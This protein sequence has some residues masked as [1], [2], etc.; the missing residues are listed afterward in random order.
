MADL[1]AITLLALAVAAGGLLAHRVRMPPALGYLGVGILFGSWQ[2]HLV[3]HAMVSLAEGGILILLFLIGLEL[4]LPR[5]RRAL[6]STAWAMPF[7][8]MVPA[9]LVAG[10]ARFMGWPFMQAVALG[11][12]M[13]VSSTLFGERVAAQP[14]TEPGA[15]QRVLGVL[16]SEDVAAGALIAILVVLASGATDLGTPA[17]A[18]GQTIF[19]LLL[20]TGAGLMLV[21]RLLD[22]VARRHVPELLVLWTL[23]LVA[24]FGYIGH[25]AGSAELGALVAGV[26]AAEAGSRFVARN[27]LTGL[28]HVAAALFFFAAGWAVDPISA[29]KFAPL[30]LLVAAAFVVAKHLVH[31]PSA[32]AAGL[33]LKASLQ[34]GAALAAIGEF[35]LILVAV[36]EREGLAHPAMRDV[37]VGAMITLLPISAL[38]GMT[39]S[40][41]SRWF[42]RWPAPVRAPLEVLVQAMRRRPKTVASQNRWQQPLRGLAVNSLLVAALM[43]L[44]VVLEPLVP[45]LPGPAY[46][47][48]A[49]WLG[50]TVALALPLLRGWYRNY[51][52]LV[53]AL[54]G[55]QPG[56]RVGAGKVRALFV[57]AWVAATVVLVLGFIS[58]WVPRTLPVVA[59]AAV[60]A[61]IIATIA[62]R[63]LTRF[64]QA[65]EA[66][67]GRVLGDDQ[68]SARFLDEIMDEYPWGVRFAAVSV[69]PRSPVAGSTL[70]ESRIGAL[71]GATVAVV[72]RGKQETVNP[73]SDTRL[74]AGDTLV[75]LGDT[76]QLSRAEA[77]VVAHGEVVRLSAQSLA[78]EVE[79]FR[80]APEST[81]IGRPVGELGIR[82]ETG[83]LVI[84][85]WLGHDGHPTPYRPSLRL[86]AGDRIILLGTPLQLQRARVLAEAIP[87]A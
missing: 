65:F 50:L 75:L 44:A 15:R 83:T 59:G 86:M 29:L 19:L 35:N 62:W 42:T 84:G 17:L 27:A 63:R 37:V 68:T 30:F 20:L 45:D 85:A 23:A 38:L 53:W 39:A 34:T 60:L 41:T 8:I 67:L 21:P 28:R 69:P 12:A 81:W 25:L 3:P 9:V 56:E 51:R 52:G 70:A 6:R 74:L 13:A 80:I 24:L 31:V 2:A 18:V 72:Q 22:E 49:V 58:I 36:A 16:I 87:V 79:E 43:A 46:T 47:E 55:L 82:D 57:D 54:V 14:G 26:A 76:A 48:T 66:A 5:L 4:D 78:V 32:S 7:D 10:A 77:L 61:T 73:P 64:H 1:A 33:N 11:L 40:K 71:T